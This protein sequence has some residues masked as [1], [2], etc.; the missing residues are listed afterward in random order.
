MTIGK[1]AEAAGVNVETVRYYERRGLIAQPPKPADGRARR[2]APSTV[3]CLRFIK[4]AQ[5]I[6]FSL[7]EISELLSL[8][9]RADASCGHVR[10]LAVQK[11]REV[12][13]RLER[14]QRIA[15]VLDEVIADCPGDG[16]LRACSI[17]EAI[18][19]AK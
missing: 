8:R 14:L 5:R 3:R 1:A 16:N 9:A 2:Y 7:K 19:R 10:D 4:D 18:E 17:L 15:G 11:R 13:D 12:Q 6:G